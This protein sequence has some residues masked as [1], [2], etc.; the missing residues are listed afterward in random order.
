M[1]RKLILLAVVVVVIGVGIAL[2][3]VLS[4]ATS[5]YVQAEKIDSL[6]TVLAAGKVT[7]KQ[8]IPLGFTV[9]GVLEG[10]SVEEGEEVNEGQVLA[11]VE[12]QEEKNRVLQRANALEIAQTQLGKIQTTDYQQALENLKQAEV[13]EKYARLEYERT[14][15]NLEVQ[16][17]ERLRQ[18]EINHEAAQTI[19]QR[20]LELFNAGITSAAELE[21]AE[22]NLDLATS[23]LALAESDFEGRFR[24]TEQAERS[25]EVARSNI[26]LAQ[27]A[28]DSLTGE[29]LKL[30]RLDA[31]QAE[32][33]LEEA[34]LAYAKTY[35]KSPTDGSITRVQASPGEFVQPGR[36]ILTFIPFADVTYVE[37]QVDED[38]TGRIVLGQEA[39]IT[40]TAFPGETF[41]ASISQVSPGI[42]AAR[43]TFRVR[44]ALERLVPELV[45][46]LAVFA[47]II[48]ERREPSIV[49]EQRFVFRQEG[50]TFV[51]TIRQERVY[52]LEIQVDN[53]GNGLVLVREGLEPGDVVLTNMDLREGQRVRLAAEER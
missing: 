36:E 15:N 30:A 26:S 2:W 13:Q 28:L 10:V 29:M 6:E 44:L 11:F 34:E 23:T 48:I 38:L 27:G 33:L 40:S 17:E 37:V 7:G 4:V 52:P 32:I 42:D 46:D 31:V 39:I 5:N 21:E 49:L 8:V 9:A 14:L 16:P 35:L 20:T 3:T 25:L 22:K 24:E 43:G 18:A 1:K 50:K 19:Y 41:P 51:N 45:P 47:E 12:N 53:L